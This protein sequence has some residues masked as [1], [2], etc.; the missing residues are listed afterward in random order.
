M[1]TGL[2]ADLGSVEA[3]ER[4]GDGA[5]LRDPHA[6]RRRA[7]ATGDSIAVNGVC[8][9][10]TAV[11]GE[12]FRAEAM[13]ETLARSSLGALRPGRAGQPR[14]GAARRRPARRPHRAGP[15]RRHRHGRARSTSDGFSRVVEIDADP[16][17][18]AL[19]R[20]EG[21]GR[22]RRR[23]PD[24]QRAA[25]R[26]LRRLADPRDARAHDPRRAA[27]RATRVNIE[28][29]MLAKHVERLM[30]AGPRMSRV[31][32]R[33]ARSRRSRRRSRTSAQG[34]MVVVCDDE[35]RENEGDLDDGRAVRDAGGDQLHGQGGARPDLPLAD[36]R[37][38]RRAR[39][40]T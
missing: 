13:P 9:T 11:D 26:R 25:R 35:D 32:H 23:Q 16:R 21:L 39:A 24:R 14:A 18:R 40:S 6:P 38:L 4:D 19:P 30:A 34:K 33:D 5:T 17:A 28:V 15:R 20:R 7:R 29:D 3:V 8:L 37:A 22:G 1:F 31:E 36:A 10:A 2:I 27:A 12:G